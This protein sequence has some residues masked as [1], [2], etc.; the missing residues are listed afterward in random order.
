MI[1]VL[2]TF[3]HVLPWSLLCLS[4]PILL[5]TE[6]PFNTHNF[7]ENKAIC[8]GDVILFILCTQYRLRIRIS[9]NYKVQIYDTSAM[10]PL[11]QFT[12]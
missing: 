7:I 2:L 3:F 12:K 8:I 10:L 4:V 6:R 1:N 5:L 9:F 11:T